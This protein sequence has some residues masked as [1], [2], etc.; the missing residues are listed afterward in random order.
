[1]PGLLQAALTQGSSRSLCT[2]SG[3]GVGGS[4]GLSMQT[5]HALWSTELGTIWKASKAILSLLSGP[6]NLSHQLQLPQ[7]GGWPWRVPVELCL[8]QVPARS[9][10]PQQALPS[11]GI[12]LLDHQ[13][14]SR[15]QTQVKARLTSALPHPPQLHSSHL[16]ASL[17]PQSKGSILGSGPH[18]IKAN[19]GVGTQT[20]QGHD[21]IC[22]VS[23]KIWG[24]KTG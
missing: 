24:D 12:Q 10:W 20:H 15:G 14:G 22:Q 8:Q 7:R 16:R 18:W 5:L 23:G 6:A 4:R 11:R 3:G 2:D 17:S 9:G 1:M 21:V 19:S 13:A